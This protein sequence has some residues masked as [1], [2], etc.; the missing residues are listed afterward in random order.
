MRLAADK[1]VAW[2]DESAPAG[3]TPEKVFI[4][5]D[6]HGLGGFQVAV[7]GALAAP[8]RAALKELFNSRKGRTQIQLVVAIEHDGEAWL[9]G[10]DPQGIPLQMP[11]EQALRQLQSVLSEPDVLA[12]TQRFAGFRKAADSTGVAGFT[13]S[14]LFASHHITQNVPKRADWLDLE[15]RA[16]PL[17]SRRGKELIQA[18]GFRVKAGPNNTMVLSIGDHPPRA[19]AILLEDAEQ[20]D[21]KAQ[22]FQLSPVAFGLAVASR[23]DVPWLVVLRKDQ[24]RLYP[25]RDGV[26]VGSKGQAETFFEIDLSI[27]DAA[28]SALLPLIFSAEALNSGGMADELLSESARYAS[29]LGARLRERIYDE[30]V[31]PLAV[32][33][34]NRLNANGAISRDADGLALAYRVTLRILFR[35]LFQAYAEDRGLLPSGRNEAFDANS[36]KANARRLTNLDASTFGDSATIWFDL[37]QVWSA[38]DHGNPQWQ[39]PA[40]NGGLFSVDPARS[41]EGALIKQ[42]ELPDRVL[43]PALKSMLIDITSDGVLG[44]VDFRSLSVREF[45]TIY[46]G[47]LESSL[48][49]AD[50]DLAVDASGAWVPAGENDIVLAS[51]GAIYFHTASG[52]R[53]ATGS[54]FTPKIVVDHLIERS[55]V[56]VLTEHLSSIAAYLAAGDSS[57]AARE[58][59]DFRVADLAMGSGHF[60]V[61]AVDKI[62]ALMRTFLTEHSVPGVTEELLRLAAVARDALGT[63]EVAKSEVDEVGLLRRQVA[64]RCIYGIDVNPMAVELARLALWIHT[65]VPGLPM[66]NLDHGLVAANSLTGIGT[67]DEA[68]DALQPG[69]QPGEM[70]LFDTILTD[71]LVSSKILL[72][73]VANASEANKAEVDE[74]ARLLADASAAAATAHAIF[75]AAV[76]ARIGRIHPGLIM[77]E[78]SLGAVLEME[79]VALTARELQPAHMPFLFPE[80]FLRDRPGFDVLLGNPPWEKIKVE[81]DQWWGLR[82]P[83]LR[84]LAQKEKIAALS[85]FRNARPDLEVAFATECQAVLAL[86]AVIKSGPF[87][88]G[89]GDTDLY[90]A[91]AWRNWQLV[92]DGGMVA[93]VLPRGA[94]S[95]SGLAA[96]RKSILARGEFKDVCFLINRGGWIFPNVDG[97]YTIALTVVSKFRIESSNEGH[98]AWAGPF[99]FQSAFLEEAADLA[100]VP[101]EEF[102]SWSSGAV[103]PL[104]PDPRSAEIFRKLRRAPAFGEVRSDFDFR[105]MTEFHATGDKEIFE[106][107]VDVANG[108]SAVFTGSSFNIWNPNAGLP[109]AYSATESLRVRLLDKLQ[110]GMRSRRSAYSGLNFERGKLPFDNARIAFRDVTNATNTRTM[111]SCL[112]PPGTTAVHKAPLLV[113]RSGDERTEAYLLGIMSSLPFDWYARRWVELTMSFELLNNLPV[114][115]YHPGSD[116]VKRMVEVA[117]RLAAFDRRYEVWADAVGVPFASVSSEAEKEDFVAEVDALA[118]L[119]FGL[120]ES[121]IQHVFET[122]HRGWD[123]EQR[124]EAVLSHYRHWKRSE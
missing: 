43:G 123:F 53:K 39:I 44:P 78:E 100:R 2:N 46:E 21:A 86:N 41:P 37:V 31:P 52:E 66:S 26:G 16:K 105:P 92:R 79:E 8:S 81:T 49:V 30:I 24:I 115:V 82:M 13:N 32:E 94:M 3:I 77:D 10:P 90:Q 74:G 72:L 80:V 47:L 106:F 34:A 96:W 5:P 124:F 45:G 36:L 116:L 64:R 63:D 99:A 61:A 93:A 55:I 69:R 84:G 25:G 1:V 33:V 15:A 110:A 68:L 29:A 75:D 50:Q 107:D 85:D 121:E 59:F 57:R 6:P 12:A 65:F 7:A 42:I 73:D 14:G 11:I 112:L 119:L 4:G 35:L 113:R 108:R 56:P 111:I 71:Q 83:G 76:A 62:E 54:Y 103:F 114:P 27:V 17:L 120:D 40:Y 91:F 122:F 87:D 109:Y 104:I 60:L 20:F 101:I 38:I 58:F 98:V 18:L 118:F 117:G 70:S 89:A 67:I 51:A 102:A 95:G 28:H 88:L 23:Q 19:V 9:F 97:R 48:S 22:R